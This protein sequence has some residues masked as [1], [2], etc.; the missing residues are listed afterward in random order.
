MIVDSHIHLWSSELAEVDWLAAPSADPIRRA[1]ALEDYAAASADLD[2]AR[3]DIQGAIVVTAE[4]SA[5]ETARLLRECAGSSLVAGVV[6]WVDLTS[7]V[8]DLPDGL[9]GVRH[10]VISEPEGWLDRPEV[11]RGIGALAHTGL[12]LEL[13]IA[14]RDLAA[15]ARCADSFPGLTIV[16]DH[17]G[18]PPADLDGWT[19]WAIALRLLARRPGVRLKAS[20]GGLQDDSLEVALESFG[21][22]R[23]MFGSDWPV[24]LLSGTLGEQV[25]LARHLTASLS[26]AERE[27]FFGATARE[28]Y[29]T[30][31]HDSVAHDNARSGVVS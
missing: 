25:S 26:E 17:L 12:V 8:L 3:F 11:R 13:L 24:S 9:S 2:I 23:L 31:D 22:G 20:G 29:G 21:A 18:N 7:P 19:A 1:F 27:Q 15:V 10:S 14:P 4:Q 16:V 6:G 28:T 30:A 5:T